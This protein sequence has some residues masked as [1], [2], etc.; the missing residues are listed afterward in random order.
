MTSSAHI[1]HAHILASTFSWK[2]DLNKWNIRVFIGL[3]I[4]H[5]AA[6]SLTVWHTACCTVHYMMELLEAV[7]MQ[8]VREKCTCM[9]MSNNSPTLVQ[10]ATCTRHPATHLCTH[11]CAGSHADTLPSIC[12]ASCLLNLKLKV[13]FFG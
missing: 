9:S 11:T 10:D 8:Q 1:I 13:S 7:A 4:L 3:T 5:W 12:L 2:F 6:C